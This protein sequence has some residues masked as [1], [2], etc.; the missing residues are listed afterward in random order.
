MR[1]EFAKDENGFIWL[2]YTKDV[3]CRRQTE[4]NGG[5]AATLLSAAEAKKRAAAE[6]EA[7]EQARQE[8]VKELTDFEA[9]VK[10][11]KD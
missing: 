5:V 7:K 9:K 6:K 11:V 8:L 4:L 1:A 10:N 3:H 2:F